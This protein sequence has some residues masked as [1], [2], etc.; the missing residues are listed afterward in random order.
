M[1]ENDKPIIREISI[2]P[3][4]NIEANEITTEASERRI[5]KLGNFDGPLDLLVTLIKEKNINI[6]DVD[7]LELANQYLEIIKNLQ[8]YEFDIASEYLVMAA[9]LLQL[10]ARMILKDPEVEEE[11][12]EEKKRLLEQIAEYEKFKE[13]S[14]VLRE[15]EEKRKNLFEKNPEETD[16]FER[17]ID[18]SVLDGHSNS[19]KLVVTLRKMF[20]RTYAELIRNVTM[21]TVAISPEEQKRRIIALFKGKK[22]LKFEEIFNVPSIGHFVITLLAILD[23]ARQQIVIL[24]QKEDEGIITFR[25]GIEYEE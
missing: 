13:I 10:K 22:E 18:S 12:K 15:Q 21:S 4:E 14:L 1:H 23:L 5:F 25:K 11:I 20:E 7:L 2:E 6:F 19:S 17:E 24:E 3:E 16:E 8:D 9:T